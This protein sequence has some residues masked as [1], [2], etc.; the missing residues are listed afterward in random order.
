M[1]QIKWHLHVP[2]ETASPLEPR[3]GDAEVI[4]CPQEDPLFLPKKMDES[5][6]L[7]SSHFPGG[8]GSQHQWFGLRE[9]LQKT[10]RMEVPRFRQKKSPSNEKQIIGQSK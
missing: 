2:A 6:I 8:P 5:P 10:G 9:T 4:P 7:S 3:C 1:Q